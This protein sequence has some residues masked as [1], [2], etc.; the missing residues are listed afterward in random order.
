MTGDVHNREGGMSVIGILLPHYSML[1]LVRK[2]LF[3]PDF[4]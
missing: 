3:C 2:I 4:T 1:I